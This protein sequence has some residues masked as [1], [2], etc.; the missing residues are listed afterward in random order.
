[1]EDVVV[2]K[3]ATVKSSFVYGAKVGEGANV[4]PFSYIRPGSVLGEGSKVG[5]FVETKNLT[6][7][8]KSKVPHLSY[9][10]DAEIG[11]NT[12]IGCGTIFANYDGVNKHSTSV[13]SNCRIGSGTILVAPVELGGNVY[14][15]A[16]A[17]IKKDVPSESLAVSE[18]TQRNIEGWYNKNRAQE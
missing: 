16:G 12:N 10:G 13:G 17:V 14:T 18:N 15:G 9:S 4:G 11:T 7:G 8:A 3:N 1:L 2:R 5:A 6:L